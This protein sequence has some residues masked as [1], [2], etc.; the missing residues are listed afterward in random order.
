MVPDQEGFQIPHQ[1]G[2]K[3]NR[4]QQQIIKINKVTFI[5]FR[6][7]RQLCSVTRG[8]QI[9]NPPQKTDHSLLDNN[10]NINKK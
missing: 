8:G 6:Y 5:I 4:Q 1:R 2:T 9:P 10:K 7:H 3:N